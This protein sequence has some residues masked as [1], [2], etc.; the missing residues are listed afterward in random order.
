MKDI[1]IIVPF[2]NSEPHLERCVKSLC[3]QTISP[4]LELV[5]VD[6]G[7]TDESVEVIKRTLKQC[8][9]CGDVVFA[10]HPINKGAAI[11]RKTGINASNGEFILFCD[12][13]DWQEPTICEE[14]LN[15]A[16]MDS[17]DM[18][19]CNY[20]SI[21][22]EKKDIMTHCYEVDLVRGLLLCRCTG[23]LCNKL[24]KKSLLEQQGFVFPLCSFCEDFAYSVQLAVAAK[25]IGYVPKP[26]YNYDHRSDSIVLSNNPERI[27]KRLFDNLQNYEVVENCL[28]AKGL[29]S[30]YSSEL[31]FQKLTIKNSIRPYVDNTVFYKIWKTIF[32]ELNKEVYKSKDVSIRQI[33]VFLCTM[34]GLYP[35]ILRIKKICGLR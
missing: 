24:F 12:S 28:R 33:I 16:R 13:D 26:L 29:Y 30:R 15:E 27:K 17:S 23:S 19:V 6:D 22:G 11:A 14:L 32:P 10:A 7:S 18:V 25:N 8:A 9:F 31:I 3:S 1:S 34:M 2:Y 20:I 21:H 35:I 5:F 4:Q